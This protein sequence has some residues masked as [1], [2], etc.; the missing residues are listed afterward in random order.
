MRCAIISHILKDYCMTCGIYRL[1][2]ENT[3]MCYIGQSVNIERRFNQHISNMKNTAATH[4]LNNAYR[5]YGTPVLE[6][7]VTCQI[8]ELDNIEDNYIEQYNS[9]DN[10]F[11]IYKSSNEAPTFD[12]TYGYGNTK[13]SKTQITEVFDYLV[14]TNITFIDIE[15]LTGV[16]SSTVSN[17]SLLYSHTWLKEAYPERY[18]IL[19]SKKGNRDSYSVISDKLSAKAKGITYPAIRSPEGEVFMIDNAYKFAKERNL[20]PNHFQEVLNKHRKSHKGWKLA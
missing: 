4:K 7:L 12:N 8:S 15:K 11:N 14:D 18:S 1:K 17:I 5:N 16:K 6:V 19:A 9:V 10:G 20:S 2:F 13:Y 3:D